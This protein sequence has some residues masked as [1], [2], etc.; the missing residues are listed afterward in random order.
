MPR[1]LGILDYLREAFFTKWNLAGLALGLGAGII[2]LRPDLFW[3]FTIA[4]ELLFLLIISQNARFQRL[5]DAK[6]AAKEA[7]NVAKQAWEQAQRL[8]EVLAK[9]PAQDRARFE[10]L[11]QRCEELLRSS[12]QTGTARGDMLGGERLKSINQLLWMFVRA[13][14]YR[15]ALDRSL[16]AGKERELRSRLAQLEKEQADPELPERTR[17]TV[18][19]N[20]RIVEERLA[21]FAKA[22]ENHKSVEAELSRIED[23]TS[24]VLERSLTSASLGDLNAQVSGV[25][26]ELESMEKALREVLGDAPVFSE[27]T[28]NVGPSILTSSTRSTSAGPERVL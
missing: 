14:S 23:L 2:T 16:D 1:K 19:E 20:R 10:K 17:A 27:S 3:P 24:L 13:L 11:R 7:Q 26:N 12:E 9:L 18:A 5:C 28:A 8:A 15:H 4:A 25:G 22:R 21:N 6:E